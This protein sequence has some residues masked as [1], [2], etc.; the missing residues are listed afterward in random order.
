MDIGTLIAQM[1]NAGEFSQLASS[2]LVQF[3]DDA[4]S[5][6]GATIL[7]EREVEDNLY[8]E[9]GIRYRTVIANDGSRYSP[10]QRK[11]GGAI[12]GDMLV[13][14]GNQDIKREMTGREYDLLVRLLRRDL[15]MDATAQVIG[16][17][18]TMVVRALVE[19][20]EKQRWDALVNAQ[21]VRLGDNGFTETVQ[22]PDPSG[23]RVTVAPAD[24]WTDDTVDPFDAIS[25][26]AEV[27][28]NKGYEVNRIITSTPVVSAMANNSLVRTRVGAAQLVVNSDRTIDARYGRVSLDGINATLQSDRL[29]PIE[30]YDLMYR[31]QEGTDYFLP[32]NTMVFLATTG[33]TMMVEDNQ[34]DIILPDTLGYLAVGRAVGQADP[35]RVLYVESFRNKPPRIEA[36]GWQT[37]LPVISDP[38]AVAVLDGMLG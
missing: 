17:V 37:S 20:N 32:R 28:R 3:G 38:E 21:V 27:L 31:T 6:L 14:L 8:R 12:V 26:M 25:S 18:D 7:P 19:L 22:Y 11:A 23:H 36:E 2:P 34:D 30:T 33:Q 10:A 35:G 29:P 13:E 16:W 15:S 9:E 4:R 24:V 1:I 5:Y